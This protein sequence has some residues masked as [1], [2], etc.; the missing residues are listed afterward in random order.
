MDAGRRGMSCVSGD[1]RAQPSEVQ[2]AAFLL[3][4]VVLP[5]ESDSPD[6]SQCLVIC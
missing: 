5:R 4:L 1:T 3:S 2:A 6:F